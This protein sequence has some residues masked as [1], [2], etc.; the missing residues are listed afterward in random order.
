MRLGLVT[1][2]LAFCAGWA[3]IALLAPQDVFDAPR[4]QH[5]LWMY[6][7]ANT[8]ELNQGLLAQRAVQP[9]SVADL[10]EYVYL[11]PVLAVGVASAYLC[12][13]IQ[14]SRLKHNISNSM[15]AGAGYF[16]TALVAMVLS[17]I[18]PGIS[19]LLV[20]A[21]LAGGGLWIGSTLIGALG[22]GIPF[23]GIASLGTVVAVGV[24]VILGGVAVL[25]VIQGLVM[26]SFAPAAVVGAGF[27]VSRS[28]ENRGRQAEYPRVAGLRE[29]LEDSWKETLATVLVVIGLAIGLNGGL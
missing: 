29:F 19:F 14:S 7:G 12:S 17:D 21:L 25:S 16:L 23:L 3:I 2:L 28:L 18:Q 22:R 4:W 13:E 20:L 15:A 6:L 10:P 27:G 8:V 1:G 26:V 9:V 24:L 11:I 5:T